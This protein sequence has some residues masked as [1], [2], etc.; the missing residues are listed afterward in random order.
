MSEYRDQVRSE[1][2]RQN[3]TL[4][5]L[6]DAARIPAAQEKPTGL[7]GML[8]PGSG[9]YVLSESKPAMRRYSRCTSWQ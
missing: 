7:Q 2:S 3:M 5:D 8:K 1:S 6:A 4:E 9:V